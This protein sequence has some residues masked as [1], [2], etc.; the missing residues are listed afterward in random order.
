[1]TERRTFDTPARSPW[2][3]PI[4]QILKAIDMHTALYLQT[5]L[6]WHAEKAAL[7]NDTCLALIVAPQA[8]DME[9]TSISA[10]VMVY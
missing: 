7:L 3:A 5:G 9:A 2:N 1:M 10:I 6:T 4:Y 8:D